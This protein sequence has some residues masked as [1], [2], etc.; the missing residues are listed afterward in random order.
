MITTNVSSG[1]YLKTETR[2]TV[3]FL[4]LSLDTLPNGIIGNCFMSGE[5]IPIRVNPRLSTFSIS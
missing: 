5:G 4:F 1:A 3:G 2:K